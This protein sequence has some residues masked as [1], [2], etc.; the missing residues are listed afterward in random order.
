MVIF[1]SILWFIRTAKAILFWVYLWQLKEYHVGRFLDHFHTAKGKELLLNPLLIAKILLFLGLLWYPV[2]RWILFLIYGAES[3]HALK[4]FF[5]RKFLKP[6][7]TLKTTVLTVFCVI[8]E[9][10]FFLLAFRLFETFFIA[11]LLLFDIAVP[12]IVSLI[13]LSFQPFA[14]LAKRRV[15][16]KAREKR[17]R[18]QNLKVIGITGSYGKTSTKELLFAILKKKFRVLKTPE[19]RNSEIGVSQTILQDINDDT[20]VFICEMGAYNKGGIKLLANI[21]KPFIG[22]LT[23]INE[24]H[25]ATFGSQENITQAKYELIESLPPTGIALFNAK[26]KYCVELYNKTNIKKVL[27]GQAAS[28]RGEEN[29]LGAMAVAKE[30]GMTDEEILSAVKGIDTTFPGARIQKGKGGL[31]IIDATYSANPDGVLAALEY[32]KTWPGKKILVMPC[33]IELG[34]ASGEVHK[35]IGK[36]IGEICDL[37]IITTRDRLKELRQ[38]AHESGMDVGK[39]WY[40]ENPQEI[41]QK[42]Q[43][44]CGAGL[45]SDSPRF[46]GEAGALAKEGDI[47]LLESRVPQPLIPMFLS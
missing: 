26:N 31:T 27:Y 12:K 38:G 21:A 13:V 30:L 41:F 40:S 18:L 34:Q 36:K 15:I 28:F 5:T 35:R 19:H 43:S 7:F 46:A 47:V 25:M 20:E 4:G 24:Q 39:V 33:L 29:I 10:I 1:L 8:L 3:A 32:L 17:A 23:G 14:V 22:V 42:I 2:L 11:L 37:A 9:L 6:V 45:P 16:Q 44:L